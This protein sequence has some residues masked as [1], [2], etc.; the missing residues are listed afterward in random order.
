M[1]KT[2][3]TT[4]A[5]ATVAPTAKIV[6]VAIGQVRPTGY[7]VKPS[8]IATRAVVESVDAKNAPQSLM[9][10]IGKDGKRD[11]AYK[12]V[13]SAGVKFYSSVEYLARCLMR[14]V[15]A[16]NAPAGTIN[17]YV[18]FVGQFP[19]LKPAVIRVFEL[20]GFKFKGAKCVNIPDSL[21]ALNARINDIMAQVKAKK[22]QK[23]DKTSAEKVSMF[24]IRLASEKAVNP[25]AIL[26]AQ[27]EAQ[28]LQAYAE[29]I[30]ER[31]KSLSAKA[32]KVFKSLSEKTERTAIEQETITAH[33]LNAQALAWIEAN[34]EA[35]L[36]FARSHVS[37]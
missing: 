3:T 31:A 9:A 11:N 33:C 15:T 32:S 18:E 21:D 29:K 19:K 17:A 22:A 36:K 14:D 25:D 27:G 24:T 7:T 8:E 5:T 23:K 34:S 1:T 4:K 16:G 6:A 13:L 26:A 12:A 30:A 28:V 2:T 20:C 37:K 10:W 35:V